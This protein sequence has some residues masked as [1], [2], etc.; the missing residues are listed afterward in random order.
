MNG[1]LAHPWTITPHYN[2]T[3]SLSLSLS[4]FRTVTTFF[5]SL[6]VSETHKHYYRST[7]L[8]SISPAQKRR[9]QS[10]PIRNDCTRTRS[11][12]VSYL[13][14][15]PLFFFFFF[16]S[17]PIIVYWFADSSLSLFK[18]HCFC[19]GLYGFVNHIKAFFYLSFK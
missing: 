13:C 18:F 4:L 15:A 6:S 17:N 19:F 1:H 2:P 9:K 8:F 5:F 14:H 10:L 7:A 3:F 16:R 11:R 12:C